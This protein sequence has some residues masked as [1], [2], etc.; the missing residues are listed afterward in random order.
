MCVYVYV[1]VLFVPDRKKIHIVHELFL[2][3]FY[4]LRHRQLKEFSQIE[5]THV[6]YLNQFHLW[7]ARCLKALFIYCFLYKFNDLDFALSFVNAGFFSLKPSL[8]LALMTSVSLNLPL[9]LYLLFL[10]IL[11]RL[12]FLWQL[13]KMLP[14]LRIFSLANFSSHN[15][16]MGHHH[17]KDF[18]DH[19][20]CSKIDF[21]HPDIFP[22]LQTYMYNCL[23]TRSLRL[24]WSLCELIVPPSPGQW[25]APLYAKFPKPQMWA[26]F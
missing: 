17:A 22:E 1:W 7:I 4:K 9:S 2:C 8:P 11:F 18:G 25:L 10:R 20:M 14:F 3:Y 19:D 21:C 6:R 5:R 12:L 23:V 15:L 13:S 24:S 26:P 16:P